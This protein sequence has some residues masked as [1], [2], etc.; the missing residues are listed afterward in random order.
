VTAVRENERT[1]DDVPPGWDH[2]PSGAAQR[3]PIVVAALVGLGAAGWLTLYQEGVTDTVWEPFF[4]DGTREIVR[5]SA[6]S[7]WFERNLP[8]GDASLGAFVYFADAVT[9]SIGGRDR[10]RRLPWMVALFAVFVVLMGA[11]SVMLTV[12]QPV[13]FD[14]FCTLCVVSALA[15]LCM[16]GPALDEVLATLQHLARVRAEGGSLWRAFWGRSPEVAGTGGLS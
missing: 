2:S 7:R 5:E 8:V 1:V 12:F 10:W 3:L 15:S 6:F 11:V 4:G 14:A 16:I 9:G 13:L